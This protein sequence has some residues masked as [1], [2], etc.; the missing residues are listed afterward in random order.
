[1]HEQ[2]R[3]TQPLKPLRR[4]SFDGAS[5]NV[6]DAIESWT[7]G[8]KVR[9]VANRGCLDVGKEIGDCSTVYKIPLKPALKKSNSDSLSELHS[10]ASRNRSI[11]IYRPTDSAGMQPRRQGRKINDPLAQSDH[12]PQRRREKPTESHNRRSK[13]V[14]TRSCPRL[15]TTS[16]GPKK[17]NSSTRPER[18]LSVP[19]PLETIDEFESVSFGD[20]TERRRQY[21]RTRSQSSVYFLEEDRKEKS[22][23]ARRELQRK[24][25]SKREGALVS[26]PGQN[27]AISDE[28]SKPLGK[29]S[30]MKDDTESNRPRYANVA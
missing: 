3:D 29:F 11:D 5:S 9:S 25:L 4:N 1:M 12:N 28:M 23:N 8:G 22:I 21:R 7:N 18:R 6:E 13:L 19:A 30:Q 15:T 10:I 17:S 26:H 16:Y 20:K 24:S 27:K 14:A 2:T